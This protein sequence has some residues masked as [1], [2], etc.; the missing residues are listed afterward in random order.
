MKS[1]ENPAPREETCT[2]KATNRSS[3]QISSSY[4]LRLDAHTLRLQISVTNYSH[5]ISQCTVEAIYLCNF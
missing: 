3:I 4:H 5:C 2:P 1:G